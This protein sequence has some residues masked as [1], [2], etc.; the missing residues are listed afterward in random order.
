MNRYRIEYIPRA[1]WQP[2]VEPSDQR[3]THTPDTF[4][5]TEEELT[6]HLS[7]LDADYGFECNFR[8]VPVLAP[9]LEAHHY[10]AGCGGDFRAAPGTAV[11]CSCPRA[12]TVD[13]WGG[14]AWT[15]ETVEMT[16]GKASAS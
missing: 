9:E 8:G 7:E 14:M 15:R 4:T 16:P 3:W 5:G 6:L 11:A 1:D 12:V 10:C 13:R 2:M